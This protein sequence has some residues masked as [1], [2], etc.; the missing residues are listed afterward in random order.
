MCCWRPF[1]QV[2]ASSLA[3]ESSTRA[4][5][6]ELALVKREA[7]HAAYSLKSA[8]ATWNS[9]LDW[10]KAEVHAARVQAA[11]CGS[12]SKAQPAT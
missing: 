4:V 10:Q 3:S 1:W 12:T 2:Q 7:A 6:A 11:A 8:V 9:E 5:Q